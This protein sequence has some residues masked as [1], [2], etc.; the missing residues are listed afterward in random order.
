MFL[1]RLK[2]LLFGTDSARPDAPDEAATP[3]ASTPNSLAPDAQ[4]DAYDTYDTYDAYDTYDP[5]APRDAESISICSCA[6][7]AAASSAASSPAAAPSASSPAAGSPAAVS[8]ASS[9][10]PEDPDSEV[11]AVRFDDVH[12]S[13]SP[14][15]PEA[16][17][18][19]SL[20]I[21]EGTFTAILGAN[22]SGK[23][24]LARH[25]NALLTP[26]SGSV[27]VF[28]LPTGDPD[29]VSDIRR[30]VGMVFQNP[31]N[32]AVATIVR[33]DVAFGPENL[34]LTSIEV[35][36]RVEEALATVAMTEHASDEVASLSGGQKQ[37]VAIAGALAMHP[38]ILVLDEPGAMLDVR[39]RRGITRVAH[40]L[41]D[42]GMTVILVTH[43][44]DDALSAD[45]VIVMD[46]GRIAL[47]GAPDEV[48]SA[49]NTA[50]LQELRLALPF[51]MQV[52]TDLSARGVD[53]TVSLSEADLADEIAAMQ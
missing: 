20:E 42:A 25:V 35:R 26:S 28:G 44:M 18:G 3:D 49:A 22:G 31:D 52:A 12:F 10:E 7:S 27:R 14:S 47:E 46:A 33:D 50:R 2:E 16:L 23:S 9:P 21:E 32:Q 11:P 41:C 39:G 40:E 15:A 43:F 24:T 45:K 53:V 6:G 8:P 19:V 29:R 1:S 5:Y 37:R 4:Q 48:F 51:S 30:Q 17:A 36:E 38:R 34:S 13:Y